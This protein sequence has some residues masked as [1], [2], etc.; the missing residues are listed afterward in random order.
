MPNSAALTTTV[1][2][3]SILGRSV[4]AGL[5]SNSSAPASATPAKMTF[6][7]ITQRHDAHSVSMP[8]SRSPT[9]APA[10][11]N[12]LK[13]PKAFGLSA[14]SVKVTL[15]S[16]SAAGASSAANSPWATRAATS[17]SKLPAAPPTTD[18]AAKPIRPVMKVVRRPNRSP[19]RP[20]SSSRLPNA[21]AYPVMTHCRLPSL[22]PRSCCASG[23]A[24][25]TTVASSVTMS[26]AT[27][28]TTSTHQRTACE[29]RRP[30]SVFPEAGASRSKVVLTFPLSRWSWADHRPETDL[31]PP[32]RK[33]DRFPRRK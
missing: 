7:Y 4:S 19:S 6:T 1:P 27:P 17:I 30:E 24:M 8:P 28:S 23:S 16:E 32:R 12:A 20:P 11:D 21:K 22:K 18:A 26:C 5:A 9:A 14:G 25:F 29:P 15:S 3:M 2:G 31:F 33:T 10:P 13:M